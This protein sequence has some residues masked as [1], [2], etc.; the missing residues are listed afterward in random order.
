[1]ADVV[2][3]LGRGGQRFAERYLG[4]NRKTI[5]KGIQ[6]RESGQP[7]EERFHE[8]GRKK[9]EEHLPLLLQDIREIVEPHSQTDPTFRSTRVYTPLTAEEVRLGIPLI[10][11]TDSGLNRPPVPGDSVHSFR[12]NRPS[13]ARRPTRM[14]LFYP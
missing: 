14:L 3:A 13:L 2:G 7:I 11:T 5:R 1:M 8:R 10:S 12:V 4:W 9:V 6:E